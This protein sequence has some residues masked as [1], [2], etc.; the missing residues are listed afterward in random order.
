MPVNGREVFLLSSILKE[1]PEIYNL[2]ALKVFLLNANKIALE[3]KKK[4]KESSNRWNRL[5]KACSHIVI[6]TVDSLAPSQ[7][8]YVYILKSLDSQLSKVCICISFTL[9]TK[10]SHRVAKR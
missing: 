1:A 4:G 10:L 3:F 8:L 6:F 7:E 5:C 9:H 2:P